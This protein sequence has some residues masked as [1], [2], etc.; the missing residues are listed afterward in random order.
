MCLF[1][2]LPIYR[3]VSLQPAR[4]SANSLRAR[5]SLEAYG[6]ASPV[7]SPSAT[8]A[9]APSSPLLH[10]R[11]RQPS[12]VPPCGVQSFPI[13]RHIHATFH[14]TTNEMSQTFLHGTVVSSPFSRIFPLLHCRVSP[15]PW[16]AIFLPGAC[17]S[18]GFPTT[19]VSNPVLLFALS[20]VLPLFPLF[21]VI[22]FGSATRFRLTVGRLFLSSLYPYSPLPPLL[23]VCRPLYHCRTSVGCRFPANLPGGRRCVRLPKFEI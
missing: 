9:T 10:G 22:H 23:S 21:T 1:A 18:Q 8:L 5:A 3:T 17:Q 15:S 20:S 12:S 16:T 6:V 2:G 4:P 7:C 11:H 14:L 19:A 13:P